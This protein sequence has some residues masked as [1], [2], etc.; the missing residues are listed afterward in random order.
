[1][2]FAIP[3]PILIATNNKG[4]FLEIKSLLDQ[5]KVKSIS[6]FEFNITKPEE[7][8]KT[9]AE[10]S[11]LKARYYALKSGLTALADDSGLC[12]EALEGAPG[13]YSSR[14]AEDAEGKK[15]DFNF[16]FAKIFAAL[17][18]KR[19]EPS[20]KPHAHFICNMTLFDPQANFKISFEG[21]VN[22]HLM[23]PPR[24]NKGFGYDPIFVKHGMN[25]TFAEIEPELKDK[26][27]HRNSAFTQLIKNTHIFNPDN[28]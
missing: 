2:S 9:F 28:A 13:I 14:F 21:R 8:G 20:E 25:Q 17:K 12:V 19:I 16:A 24:G 23:F 10:N 27:S 1:M 6:A 26:I 4:K 11:L 15:S 18:E 3:S 5:I 7:N 22:G